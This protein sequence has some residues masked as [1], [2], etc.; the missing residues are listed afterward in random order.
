MISPHFDV[1]EETLPA[2]RSEDYAE[3]NTAVPARNNSLQTHIGII[4]ASA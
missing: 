4:R 1:K 2:F 3:P